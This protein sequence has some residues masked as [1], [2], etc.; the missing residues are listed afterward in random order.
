MDHM[1]AQIRDRLW[2]FEDFDELVSKF[3]SRK[4]KNFKKNQE[5]NIER[6]VKMNRYEYIA[7]LL[8]TFQACKLKLG[9]TSFYFSSKIYLL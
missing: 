7:G 5:L 6:R 2:T 1:L 3:G 9:K 4:V 8:Q